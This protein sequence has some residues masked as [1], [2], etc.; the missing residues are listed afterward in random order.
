M[1]SSN[2]QGNCIYVYSTILCAHK[3]LQY[4]EIETYLVD[5]HDVH[6]QGWQVDFQV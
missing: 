2:L 4:V 6:G 3:G 5:F 1:V